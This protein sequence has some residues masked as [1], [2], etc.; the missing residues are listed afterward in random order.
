MDI[1]GWND[2]AY[3]FLLCRHGYVFEGRGWDVRSAATGKDNDHTLAACFLGA[4][5]AGRD[6]L[7]N[8]G[9]QAAVDIAR[10]FAKRYGKRRF[11]GHRDFVSTACPGDEL[12]GFIRSERF[13][14]LVSAEAQPK[15]WPTP[16]PS[17]FWEWAKW[18]LG[19]R[20]GARP[21]VAPATIPDWAWRRLEAL[22]A[23]RKR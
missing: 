16:I 5:R 3:S 19:G 7:T 8:G 6:D 14:K 20:K 18:R 2:I 9:R 10:M 13:R 11:R 23:A 4:D 12:H 21:A 22:Q 15:L 1:R 17:W